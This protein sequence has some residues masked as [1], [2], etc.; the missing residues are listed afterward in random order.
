MRPDACFLEV[1]CWSSVG[2]TLLVL[3]IWKIIL[4]G[5]IPGWLSFSFST[6]MILFHQL[7]SSIV[8]VE[9]P[10]CDSLVGDLFFCFLNAF[11]ISLSLVVCTFTTMCLNLF[12]FSCLVYVVLYIAEDSCFSSVLESSQPRSLQYFFSSILSNVSFWCTGCMWL[13]CPPLLT[14]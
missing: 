6:L 1:P 13:F 11:K 2:G 7:Q 9:K 4:P 14:S 12:Y 8:D 3:F 10:A 5:I